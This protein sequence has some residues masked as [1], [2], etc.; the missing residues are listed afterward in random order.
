MADANP[1]IGRFKDDSADSPGPRPG[2]VRRL[3]DALA[4]AVDDGD[5]DASA[6]AHLKEKAIFNIV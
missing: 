4:G 1:A 5:L 3:V 6:K 2:T